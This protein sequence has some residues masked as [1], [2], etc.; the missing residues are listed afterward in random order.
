MTTDR[1][2]HWVPVLL[3]VFMVTFKNVLHWL[4]IGPSIVLGLILMMSIV[5]TDFSPRQFVTYMVMAASSFQAL[6]AAPTGYLNVERCLENHDYQA[7]VTSPVLV[8]TETT[9]Q[10]ATVEEVTDGL[11]K[12]ATMLYLIAV[13]ITTVSTLL[14]KGAVIRYSYRWWGER[15]G[16]IDASSMAAHP[17]TKTVD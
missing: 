15:A 5:L 3:R 9:I 14:M 13:L 4:V 2:T 16:A 17:S 1:L 12:W 7:T 8:C 11:M 10:A 6:G